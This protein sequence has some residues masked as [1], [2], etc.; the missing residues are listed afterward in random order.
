[1]IHNNLMCHN[2]TARRAVLRLAL[3][4]ATLSSAGLAWAQADSK[5]CALVLMHDRGGSAAPMAALGRKLQATCMVKAVEMPW[6]Q[7]RANDKD[8][9]GAWQEVTRHIRD[10]RQQGYKRVLVGGAGFGANAAMAYAGA[11]GDA[12]GVVALAP[13]ADAPGIGGLPATAMALRQHTPVLWV[14]G[15]DD[16]LFQRGEAF[17]FAKA[18]PHPQ[19]RYETV[20]ADRKGTADAASKPLADWLKS[21]E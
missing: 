6:S 15:T 16:P 13:E 3:A 7:R 14:L 12:D 18:P 2:L 19:S 20:K 9:P 17:A 11:V 5:A 1:M 4:A 10:L 8:L 21:L